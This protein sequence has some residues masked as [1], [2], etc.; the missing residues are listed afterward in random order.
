MAIC[1]RSTACSLRNHDN[2]IPH[3]ISRLL[4]IRD[5]RIKQLQ[6]SANDISGDPIG[7]LE[8]TP[9]RDSFPNC[10]LS[11]ESDLLVRVTVHIRRRSPTHHNATQMDLDS[12]SHHY[13]AQTD[14]ASVPGSLMSLLGRCPMP[15]QLPSGLIHH[16]MES[17]HDA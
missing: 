17:I 4:K 5:R 10:C 9:S 16:T 15:V 12:L 1:T 8:N 13:M 6:T 14:R 2:Q 7:D 11:S 3:S